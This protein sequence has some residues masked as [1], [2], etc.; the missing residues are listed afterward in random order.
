MAENS[1]DHPNATNRPYFLKTKQKPKGGG[2]AISRVRDTSPSGSASS[3]QSAESLEGPISN[4]DWEKTLL[5]WKEAYDVGDVTRELV[6]HREVK[7]G[8]ARI[9]PF[10]GRMVGWSVGGEWCVVVGSA[11]SLAVFGRK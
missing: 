9:A 2:G 11:G 1:S 5:G 3:R 7:V 4:V 8:D 6:A 10:T